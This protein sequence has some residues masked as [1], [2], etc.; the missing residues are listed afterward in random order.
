VFG[1]GS[2]IDFHTF[3]KNGLVLPVVALCWGD[4]ADFAV[5]VSVVVPLHELLY[6]LAGF[7]ECGEAFGR[8]SISIYTNPPDFL[9][10]GG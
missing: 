6:P 10:I 9:I 3:G 7:F 2:G 8:P 5:L 1:F 4:K